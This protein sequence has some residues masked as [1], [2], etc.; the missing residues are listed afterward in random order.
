MDIAIVGGGIVGTCLAYYLRESD[1]DVVLYE[2]DELG[3]WTTGFSIGCFQW[4]SNYKGID[5]MIARK[6]W[7]LYKSLMDDYEALE[8]HR[9][10]TLKISRNGGLDEIKKRVEC[11]KS[12]G[13]E[14]EILKP[15]E[16]AEYNVNPEVV[17]GG[18]AYY[19]EAGRLDPERIIEGL[20]KEIEGKVDVR[21]QTEV[22]DVSKDN[23]GVAGIETKD[24]FFKHNVVVNAAGP[25]A[26]HLNDKVDEPLPIKHTR[27][28]ISVLEA[29]EEVEPV[30]IVLESGLYF[31]GQIE[32]PKKVLAGSSPHES[33]DVDWED[34]PLFLDPQSEQGTG[35]GA[36]GSNHIDTVTERA[37]DILLSDIQGRRNDEGWQGLRCVTRD[38]RPIVGETSIDRYYVA[39]GLSGNGIT[40]GPGCAKLLARYIES[41][42]KTR[43]LEALSPDRFN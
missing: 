7:E 23:G 32:E 2:K 5:Y 1:H 24:S 3:D 29:K 10:G 20:R 30:T 14:A 38:E 41:G 9:Y 12:A 26:G 8:F 37:T 13:I 4:D 18:A 39:T 11:R 21:T 40:A 28:P 6:S 36:V 34:L 17:N 25:W 15:G 33:E 27:A 19:P 42:Q 16:L 22:T 31:S 35:R 43:E